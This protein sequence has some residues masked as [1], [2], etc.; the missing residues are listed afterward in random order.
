M[1]KSQEIIIPENYNMKVENMKTMI[2]VKQ[3]KK[4]I[5]KPKKPQHQ[6]EPD[7][8]VSQGEEPTKYSEMIELANIIDIQYLDSYDHWMRIM[9]DL[10]MS[11]MVL[12]TF[13][14][15]LKPPFIITLKKVMLMNSKRLFVNI[16]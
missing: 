14:G 13:K 4:L 16:I 12:Q 6:T 15:L 10:I 8:V 1:K 7:V 11:G 3:K 2:E 9:L 5:I